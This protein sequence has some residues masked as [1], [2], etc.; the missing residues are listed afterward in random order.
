MVLHPT[1]QKKAQAELDAV[2]GTDRLPEFSDEDSLPYVTAVLKE[3]LRWLPVAPQAIAHCTNADDEYNGYF[4]PKGTTVIGN[5]WAILH[6]EERYPE[7][8]KYVPE[9]FLK[10]GKINPQVLDPEVAAFGFGRRFVPVGTS[11]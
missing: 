11:F 10:D 1:E 7:P 8:F 9:R 4:I 2:V 5:S 3:T 6:D